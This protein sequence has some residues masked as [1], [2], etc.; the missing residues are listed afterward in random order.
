MGVSL[1]LFS[2]VKNS[3]LRIR[4]SSSTFLSPNQRDSPL[5]F[6]PLFSYSQDKVYVTI[7][8]LRYTLCV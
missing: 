2:I 5:F 4:F 6:Y 8:D 7:L 1:I 3:P